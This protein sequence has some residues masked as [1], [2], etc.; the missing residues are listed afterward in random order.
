M[1]ECLSALTQ[2]KI[3]IWYLVG[4]SG[5]IVPQNDLIQVSF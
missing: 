5:H 3:K 4:G 2:K 1:L